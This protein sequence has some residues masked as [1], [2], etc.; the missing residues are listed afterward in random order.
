MCAR[1]VKAAASVLLAALASYDANSFFLVA[2][3]HNTGQALFEQLSS[4]AVTASPKAQEA[5]FGALSVM[6]GATLPLDAMTLANLTATYN[7][8]QLC[9]LL[10]LKL[11]ECT[12]SSA[13][14]TLGRS[15]AHIAGHV[16]TALARVVPLLPWNMCVAAIT[17]VLTSITSQINASYTITVAAGRHVGSPHT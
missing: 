1:A 14:E 17:F 7:V 9:N 15:R 4:P 13:V 2:Q 8:A 16:V 10:T 11:R 12:A 6:L 3:Q 5:L